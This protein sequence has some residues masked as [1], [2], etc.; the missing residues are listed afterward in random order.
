M[1]W[2][3]QRTS[4]GS[5]EHQNRDAHPSDTLVERDRYDV[6]QAFA[7]VKHTSRDGSL[8]IVLQAWHSLGRKGLTIL[9][10]FSTCIGFPSNVFFEIFR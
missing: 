6:R 5:L 10:S 8:F 9:W 7:A 1:D 2:N 3:Y 4:L